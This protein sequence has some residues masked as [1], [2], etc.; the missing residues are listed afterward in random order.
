MSETRQHLTHFL[1]YRLIPLIGLFI[2]GAVIA[3][4][5]V[6]SYRPDPPADAIAFAYAQDGEFSIYTVSPD[7]RN[8]ARLVS[9][10]ST[11]SWIVDAGQNAPFGIKGLSTLPI[12]DHHV[13]QSPAWLSSGHQIAYRIQV[14][15]RGAG[16]S[17]DEIV[18]IDATG[19]NPQT[20]T[21]LRRSYRAEAVDWS[22]DGYFFAFADREKDDF[23]I[24]VLDSGGRQVRQFRLQGLVWGLA[25]SPDST[26]IAAAVDEGASL[27]IYHQDGTSQ[28]FRSEAPA[29]GKPTWSPDGSVVAFLCYVEERIDLCTMGADGTDFSRLSFPLEFPFIKTDIHWSPTGDQIVFEALQPSGFNDLFVIRAHGGELRQLT[30]H[31]AGDSEPAW[32]PDGTQIT[33]VSMRDGNREIYI[34]NADGTGLKRVT[35]TPGDEANP[36]W[37]P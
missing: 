27:H 21:C 33:F 28:R 15:G 32:S 16:Q 26:R 34:V 14:L 12:V 3:A 35:E 20:V 31:P 29:F 8:R 23:S 37:R 25:W 24:N 22:P 2:V 7:G 19:K 30:F 11:P 9:R 13:L 1:P 6:L 5:M 18:L 4:V 10:Y 36:V 17:C